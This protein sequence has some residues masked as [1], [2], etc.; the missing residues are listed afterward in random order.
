MMFDNEDAILSIATLLV[1]ILLVWLI[2]R[3][4]RTWYWKVNHR[5]DELRKLNHGVHEMN[6]NLKELTAILA[7]QSSTIAA[8]PDLLKGLDIPENP[9]DSN[10]RKQ[11]RMPGEAPRRVKRDDDQLPEL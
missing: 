8:K 7:S 10:S 5:L 2:T 4:F 11:A 1:V 3:E 6:K 9:T